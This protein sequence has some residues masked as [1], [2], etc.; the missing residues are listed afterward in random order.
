M[1]SPFDKS[2]NDSAKRAWAPTDGPWPAQR[3][4][5]RLFRAAQLRAFGGGRAVRGRMFEWLDVNGDH[6]AVTHWDS[7]SYLTGKASPVRRLGALDRCRCSGCQLVRQT[8]G[9]GVVV[10]RDIGG[11]VDGSDDAQNRARERNSLRDQ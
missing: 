10:D 1:P 3:L 7:P 5:V 8:G 9:S 11:R 6:A 4:R 2:T